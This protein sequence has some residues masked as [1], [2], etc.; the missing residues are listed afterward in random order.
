MYAKSPFYR[1]PSF[2][3]CVSALVWWAVMIALA[4]CLAVMNGCTLL[5][6]AVGPTAKKLTDQYC[7]QPQDARLLLRAQVDAAITPNKIAVSCANDA[8]SNP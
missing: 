6:T 8:N 1:L 3:I 7:S 4:I 5:Q 2:K